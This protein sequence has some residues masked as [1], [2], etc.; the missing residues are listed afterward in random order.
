MCV[1]YPLNAK[2]TLHGRLQGVLWALTLVWGA[3]T[4]ETYNR[5]KIY[6]QLPAVMQLYSRCIPDVDSMYP[7]VDLAVCYNGFLSVGKNMAIIP[8]IPGGVVIGTRYG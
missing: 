8:C 7:D 4:P 1:A 2:E 6:P 5:F 3:V